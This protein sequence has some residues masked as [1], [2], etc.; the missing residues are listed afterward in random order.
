M[1]GYKRKLRVFN[2]GKINVVAVVL[3]FVFA[4][5]GLAINLLAAKTPY[6]A[7]GSVAGDIGLS[8]GLIVVG[9]FAHEGLH[10]LAAMLFGKV[11]PSDIAFGFKIKDGLLYCHCK[12]P[13]EG[14]AYCLMLVLPLIFT[15]LVPFAICTALGG[16]MQI[17]VFA[18][19]IAGAAG[20]VIML[21]GV[22][23]NRDTQRTVLDHPD[24]TAYYAYYPEGDLPEGFTETT[25]EEE[26][27][28][29][30]SAEVRDGKKLGIKV[31]LIALFVALTVLGLFVIGLFMEIV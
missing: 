19:L 6:L 18:L 8:V 4:A 17:C 11:R 2:L 27:R 12:K 24:M 23:S 30:S 15:G 16:L 14:K 13:L 20:D 21:C 9:L 3:F 26:T 7:T 1:E 31:L 29:L 10:G 28:I 22:I 5:I 25:E